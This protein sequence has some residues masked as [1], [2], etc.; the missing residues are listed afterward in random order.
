MS[1]WAVQE[2]VDLAATA[3]PDVSWRVGVLDADSGDLLA[4]RDPDT[5]QR[6]ASL[7]KL[8][9][10]VEVARRIEDGTLDPAQA[11]APVEDDLVRDS[12]L[13]WHLS[14]RSLPL[15][16]CAALV[17]AF[18][19]NLAT[20]VLLRRVGGPEPVRA[21]AQR[22]A[23][24]G[25]RLHR[26]VADT[27]PPPGAGSPYGL[28]SGTARAY[29]DLV[30]RLHR[31][32]VISPAVCARVLGWLGLN[33]DL[34]MVGGAFGLDPLCHVQS[35]RGFQLWNKTGTIRDVLADVGV[36]SGPARVVAYAVLTERDDAHHPAGRDSALAGMRVIGAALRAA[37]EGR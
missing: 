20:N 29:A 16:D 3:D 15:A 8:L 18:S 7:G 30:A 23:L 31:R 25:V 33:A 17:G 37:V 35:D 32:D 1:S 5:I 10:L 12:G 27:A 22:A 2:A 6:T 28:S 19:D 13:W 9:L 11:L 21:T 36:V 34:S 26:Q 24:D 4:H 14:A